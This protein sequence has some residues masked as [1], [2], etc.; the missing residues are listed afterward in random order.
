MVK[1][2]VGLIV[3]VLIVW[4]ITARQDAP[5]GVDELEQSPNEVVESEATES[6]AVSDLTVSYDGQ[7][8]SPA[9]LNVVAGQSVMFVNNSS[10]LMWV[11]SDPH[12]VHT[13]LSGFDSKEGIKAGES[14]VFTFSEV[15]EWGYHNHLNSA[16]TGMVIV[17]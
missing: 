15:G 6:E 3:I 12:P 2:V 5:T 7:N 16:Q 17:Q 14:Y 9:T 10:G 13:G 8:F 11:A 4:G 1:Y